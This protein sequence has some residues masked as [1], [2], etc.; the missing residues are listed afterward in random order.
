MKN[1]IPHYTLFAGV[2]GA[3]K[4]TLYNNIKNI[5]D[6]ANELG[7]RLNTDEIVKANGE[8]WRDMGA[9]IKAGKEL[10]RRQKDCFEN[11]LSMNQETTLSGVT[12]INT[13]QKAKAL[14]YE[15]NLYYVG[16]ASDE[17]AKERVAKRVA[18]GG[19]GVSEDTLEKRFVYSKENLKQVIPLCNKVMIY[20][21][22]DFC[23]KVMLIEKGQ[24]KEKEPCLWAENLLQ[25]FIS[26]AKQP[27]IVPPLEVHKTLNA[28]IHKERPASDAEGLTIEKGEKLYTICVY[29]GVSRNCILEGDDGEIVVARNVPNQAGKLIWDKFQSFGKGPDALDRAKAD[30]AFQKNTHDMK[31]E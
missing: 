7:V 11:R 23:K 2:N 16:V 5:G 17:I 10:F 30:S 6:I 3:G 15:V 1:D 4:S 27:R 20:D 9:Q 19:H 26:E 21:N 18:A 13:I 12:I 22:T 8:D 31:M 29:D 28:I 24:V 25:E 14:G